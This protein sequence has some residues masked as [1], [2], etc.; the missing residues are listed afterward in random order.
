[1]DYAWWPHAAKETVA[2]YRL[3]CRQIVDEFRRR[4]LNA[5]LYDPKSPPKILVL[6]KRYD[7]DSITHALDMRT[8]TGC[9]IVLD[10]CDNHFYA[11][12]DNEEWRTRA[13]AVRR[14]VTAADLTIASTPALAGYIRE[15][16]GMDTALAIVGDAVEHPSDPGLFERLR[17]PRAE[18]LLRALERQLRA[19][20]GHR[21]LVWFGNHG[22]RFAEGGMLDL[23]RIRD[24]LTALHRE[25]PVQ[26]TVISNNEQKFVEHIA[27]LPIPAH[28]LRWRP[29][30]F[31]RALRMQEFCLIPIGLNPFTA[32][33]SNNRLATALLHGL[34][35]AAD[36]LPAYEDFAG[37]ALLGD[38][39]AGLKTA[40]LDAAAR[41]QSVA[42]GIAQ[43]ERDWTLEKIAD[44]WL[45]ALRS[46]ERKTPR[47][48]EEDRPL[49]P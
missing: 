32:C 15:A 26:L 2:S 19:R 22:A 4:G 3:R 12:D 23:L 49:N 6:G 48:N 16:C 34:G 47:R 10:L 38:W 9:K 1:M 24:E 42:A 29:T 35:V 18:F 11:Q 13:E 31:S 27:P 43:I 30:T 36:R 14:A 17:D 8:R 7:A 33:K 46:L 45:G 25:T 5:G 37:A 41:R 21:R 20:P 39:G 40:L 28:Y 44:Q